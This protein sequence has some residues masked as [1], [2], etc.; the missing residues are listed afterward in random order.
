MKYFLFLALCTVVVI[1]GCQK[2]DEA[3]A[4]AEPTMER[5]ASHPGSFI[6]NVHA[7]ANGSDSIRFTA[8]SAYLSITLFSP[9][10]GQNHVLIKNTTTNTELFNDTVGVTDRQ[11]TGFTPG[12]NYFIMCY[13]G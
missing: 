1:N 5:P 7:P 3:A 2:K 8:D 12:N 10:G 9:L 11:V 13:S 4:K 6:T